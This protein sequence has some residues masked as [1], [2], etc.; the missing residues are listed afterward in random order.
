MGPFQKMFL[1]KIEGREGLEK[2]T[3]IGMSRG[4]FGS[5]SKICNEAF[6]TK[7]VNDL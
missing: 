7:I 1:Q 2:R 6:I 3:E 5:Q 4:V